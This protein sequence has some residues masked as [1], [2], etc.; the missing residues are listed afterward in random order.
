MLLILALAIAASEVRESYAASDEK[1]AL[2]GV[3]NFGRIGAHVY[4]EPS[5]R[6]TRIRP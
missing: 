3:A 4:R 6:L 2:P 5:P 1:L